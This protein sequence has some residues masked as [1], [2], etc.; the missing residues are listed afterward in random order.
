[1]LF[2]TFYRAINILKLE[3]NTYKEISKDKNS[4]Y[5]SAAIIFLQFGKCLFVQI[6][7]TSNVTKQNT[8]I[9]NFVHVDI[10][11]LVC[12]FKYYVDNSKIGRRYSKF[13][14]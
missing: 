1:M 11:Q 13:R 12:F 6:I 2:Q 3:K 8:I 9:T 4:I 5:G 7:Y 14:K 10:F